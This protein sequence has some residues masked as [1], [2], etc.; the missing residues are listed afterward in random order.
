L[1]VWHALISA[2]AHSAPTTILTA[3]FINLAS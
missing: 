1:A 3:L 2:N